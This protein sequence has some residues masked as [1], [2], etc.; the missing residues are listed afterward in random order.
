[1]S[2][3]QEF[4]ERAKNVH[5]EKYDYSH[6]H[7]LTREIEV[8]IICPIHGEFKQKPFV[9]LRGSGCPKCAGKHKRSLIEFISEAN[10]VHN[11]RYQYTD[12]TFKK[13]KDKV[14]IFCS[15]HGLFDQRPSDHLNG[16]GCPRCKFDKLSSINRVKTEEFIKRAKLKHNSF[17]SYSAVEYIDNKT[18]VTISCPI[19]GE[20]KQKPFIHL[21]G[22]GCKKCKGRLS[23]NTK[24]FVDLSSKLHGFKYDYKNVIYKSSK[25]LVSIICPIHG[26][27][28]QIPNAHLNGAGCPK[29]NLFG[30]VSENKLYQE[31]KDFFGDEVIQSYKCKWLGKQHLDIYI[32]SL[33][34][35]I[36][37]Q[38]GQHFIPIKFFGGEEGLDKVKKRDERKRKLCIKNNI[39]LY[40]F[41][42]EIQYVP[43][44]YKYVVFK[45]IQ[46]L[47]HSI[48]SS[49][50]F[51][52]V[53]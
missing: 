19:H 34:V 51:V 2:K 11:N 49:V 52:K 53:F 16:Q 40:Y 30:T 3:N 7:Y 39:K 10:K 38:G 1:M 28:K 27:F 12:T 46:T 18:E 29:C 45:N 13:M 15:V 14:Q 5:G 44:D 41:T 9:H 25:S 6:V 36:E 26:E 17:Y 32:P 48:V 24:E 42:N 31:I 33:K 37:Y 4:I 21:D 8:D 43:E 50:H 47:I 22:S 35:A 20:F 23:T